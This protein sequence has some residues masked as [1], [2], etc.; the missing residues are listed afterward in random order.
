MRPTSTDQD[1][2][3][4]P[5]RS[6]RRRLA[7]VDNARGLDRALEAAQL[8]VADGA[9]TSTVG[10]AGDREPFAP[11]AFGAVDAADGE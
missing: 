3:G 5:T 11:E 2:P 9:T 4:E 1:P 8:R 10:V 7:E 6:V